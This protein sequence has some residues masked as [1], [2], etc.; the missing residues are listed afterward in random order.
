MDVCNRS[1]QEEKI[2]YSRVQE[3]LRS[4]ITLKTGKKELH[5]NLYILDNVYLIKLEFVLSGVWK[6]KKKKRNGNSSSAQ[7][8]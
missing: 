3:M 1:L 6:L 5:V 2:K 7:Y 4:R 8:F